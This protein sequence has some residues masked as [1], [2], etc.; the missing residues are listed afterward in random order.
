ML[1]YQRHIPTQTA[2]TAKVEKLFTSKPNLITDTG[3]KSFKFGFVK[4][5]QE[6]ND[7]I[8]AQYLKGFLIF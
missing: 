2:Q 4:P 3:Y 8:K 5:H 7:V 6:I 1:T